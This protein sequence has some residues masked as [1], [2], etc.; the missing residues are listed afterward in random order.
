MK[1]QK[2]RG[3][4]LP[5]LSFKNKLTLNTVCGASS[6]PSENVTGDRNVNLIKG[7]TTAAKALFGRHL[8]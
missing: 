6:K 2:L 1:L 5:G 8:Q 7:L 3:K 4:V